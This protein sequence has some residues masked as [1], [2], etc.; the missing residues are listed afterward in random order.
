[1]NTRD[2]IK[3]VETKITADTSVVASLGR[4]GEEMF[5]IKPEQT[6]FVDCMGA[7]CS[8]A[9]GIALAV[10][11]GKPVIALDTDG[12]HLMDISLLS[13]LSALE[14]DLQNLTIIVIDNEIYESGGGMASGSS[15]LDWILLAKAWGLELKQASS[16]EE[17]SEAFSSFSARFTYIVAKV[18]DDERIQ[19][20][21]KDFD[22]IESRYQF[23]RHLQ[24]I[25]KRKLI[26][27]AIKG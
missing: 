20:F 3:F 2:V 24:R 17:L 10:G 12:S 14:K 26:E 25:T 6:L 1:M 19:A 16:G 13:T 8:L 27:P 21:T 7:V 15:K 11:K 23:R 5:R 18:K 9:C 4:T 22:G